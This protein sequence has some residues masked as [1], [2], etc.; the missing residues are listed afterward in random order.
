VTM[1]SAM[2]TAAQIRKWRRAWCTQRSSAKRR[3]IAFTLTFEDWLSIW[4]DSGHLKNRGRM[5]GQFVM[6][7]PGDVG[8]YEVGNVIITRCEQNHIDAAPRMRGIPKTQEHKEK[9]SI[10]MRGRKLT[11]AHKKKI[12]KGLRGKTKG[13]P[14]SEEHRRKISFATMGRVA[15]NK[16]LK[17]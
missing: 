10:A 9:Q 6:A 13:I 5:L 16:G 1:P 2:P 17:K 11:S 12:S 4:Q 7:R 14:K 8:S 15:W 3:G